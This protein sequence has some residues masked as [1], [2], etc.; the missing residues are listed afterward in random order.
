[1]ECNIL[2]IK[3]RKDLSRCG[4]LWHLVNLQT[5]ANFEF[6]RWTFETSKGKYLIFLFTKMIDSFVLFTD[7]N[8]IRVPENC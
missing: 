1:M 4:L 6:S 5:L 8:V 3:T 2:K 7:V